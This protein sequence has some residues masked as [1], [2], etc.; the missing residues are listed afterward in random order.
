ML[1]ITIS[2]ILDHHPAIH[3]SFLIFF[4]LENSKQVLAIILKKNII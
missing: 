2:M 1:V 3:A 4:F